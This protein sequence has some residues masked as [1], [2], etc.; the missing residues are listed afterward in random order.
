[1]ETSVFAVLELEMQPTVH[2]QWETCQ[3]SK[4]GSNMNRAQHCEFRLIS[5]WQ[6]CWSRVIFS[7]LHLERPPLLLG[8]LSAFISDFFN[9]FVSAV[10][11]I[12]IDKGQVGVL[13]YESNWMIKKKRIGSRSVTRNQNPFSSSWHEDKANPSEPVD[14]GLTDG[15]ERNSRYFRPSDILTIWWLH[16]HSYFEA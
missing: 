2:R 6:R 1:M 15:P 4:F 14:S 3:F 11:G 8:L 9:R 10:N 5:K 7:L 12:A 16:L 13:L